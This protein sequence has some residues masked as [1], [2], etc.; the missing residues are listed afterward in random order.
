MKSKN[1]GHQ[2]L[3][4]LCPKITWKGFLFGQNCCSLEVNYLSYAVQHKDNIKWCS[5]KFIGTQ[6]LRNT[7]LT[8]VNVVSVPLKTNSQ[9]G[10]VLAC[11]VWNWA[12]NAKKC[13]SNNNKHLL[14][15]QIFPTKSYFLFF[16]TMVSIPHKIRH[17]EGRIQAYDTWKDSNAQIKFHPNNKHIYFPVI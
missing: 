5:T 15:N 16:S 9:R 11:D 10:H 1:L 7:I 8:N 12:L 4:L 2:I 17:R 13:W 3:D 6:S 14:L